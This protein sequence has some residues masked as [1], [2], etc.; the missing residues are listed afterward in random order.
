MDKGKSPDEIAEEMDKFGWDDFKYNYTK[1]QIGQIKRNHYIHPSCRTLKSL[2][3][4]IKDCEY[5][6]DLL[7]SYIKNKKGKR[8]IK[9]IYQK[10]K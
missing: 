5:M 7:V 6:R 9:K 8:K 3:F 10:Q 2:G 4:C 1:Y